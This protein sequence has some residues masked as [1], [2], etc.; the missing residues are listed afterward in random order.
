MGEGNERK[1]L[2]RKKGSM[3]SRFGRSE[4]RNK[5]HSRRHLRRTNRRWNRDRA[6]GSSRI[7]LGVNFKGKG[8]LARFNSI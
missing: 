3:L 4:S 6:N 5:L 8:R 1:R 7:D 2:L